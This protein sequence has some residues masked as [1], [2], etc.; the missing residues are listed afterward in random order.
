MGALFTRAYNPTWEGKVIQKVIAEKEKLMDKYRTVF[1]V[2]FLHFF[3]LLPFYSLGRN[4]LSKK[5]TES[6]TELVHI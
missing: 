3:F 1:K 2:H 4:V 6:D 5:V